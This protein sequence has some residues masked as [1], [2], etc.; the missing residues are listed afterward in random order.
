[1][2]AM[3]KLCHSY[4]RFFS[5]HSLQY[6][7]YLYYGCCYLYLS[8]SWHWCLFLAGMELG[9]QLNPGVYWTSKNNNQEDCRVIKQICPQDE[10]P[11]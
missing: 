11:S 8:L 7:L 2:A 6:L 3:C 1:M 10:A 5:F 9:I 4:E